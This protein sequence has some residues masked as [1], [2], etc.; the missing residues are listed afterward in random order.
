[1]IVNL[2][3]CGYFATWPLPAIV[4]ATTSVLVAARNL[5]TAWLARALGELAYR[6]WISARFAQTRW[7]LYLFCVWGQALLTAAV[8]GALMFFCPLQL[9]PFAV[10]MGIVTYAAA[11]AFYT[12]LAAWRSRRTLAAMAY[13]EHL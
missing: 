4:I 8:G 13:S 2:G 3:M 6:S 10:G 1:V 11:V 7:G 12:V 9:V 5:Q